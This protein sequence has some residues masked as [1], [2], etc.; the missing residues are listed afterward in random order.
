M[1]YDYIATILIALILAIALKSHVYAFIYKFILS[2]ASKTTQKTNGN[3]KNMSTASDQQP[4]LIEQFREVRIFES[5]DDVRSLQIVAQS[6]E[7]EIHML[8][9]DIFIKL[10]YE[11]LSGEEDPDG[12][13]IMCD[14]VTLLNG[15]LKDLDVRLL[16]VDGDKAE[17]KWK[18]AGAVTRR[19]SKCFTLEFLNNQKLKLF[20][21]CIKNLND[22]ICQDLEISGSEYEIISPLADQTVANGMNGDMNLPDFCDKLAQAIHEGNVDEACLFAAQLAQFKACLDITMDSKTKRDS[23]YYSQLAKS[24]SSQSFRS[25][26]LKIIVFLR[27]RPNRKSKDVNNNQRMIEL[28]IDDLATYTVLKFKEAVAKHFSIPVVKQLVA[29]N[30]FTT[31]ADTDLVSVY[32]KISKSIANQ[33]G[34]P[35]TSASANRTSTAQFVAHVFNLSDGE[36]SRSSGR[37][38]DTTVD[39]ETERDDFIDFFTVKKKHV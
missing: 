21:E 1:L 14:D 12:S 7:I 6:G 31:Q 36:M 25:D 37:D 13:L 38:S 35:C 4:M 17:I 2:L 26:T 28:K 34:S 9:G 11:K 3:T 15:K 39:S 27:T 22:M 33:A 18:C 24:Q 20:Q 5:T 30:D 10:V 32:S 29:I 23:P 19:T 8:N 16:C